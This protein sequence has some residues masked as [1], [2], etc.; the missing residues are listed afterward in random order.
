MFRTWTL[1]LSRARA[2]LRD[3]DN[4]LLL[5]FTS[6]KKLAKQLEAQYGRVRAGSSNLGDPSRVYVR[7]AQYG[8]R[9]VLS[10]YSYLPATCKNIARSDAASGCGMFGHLP[11]RV[12][13]GAQIW[14]IY[15]PPGEGSEWILDICGNTK[16]TSTI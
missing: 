1:S 13:V 5:H 2:D 15:W 10:S 14:G 4:L 3:Q 7:K 11:E 6:A 12:A 9:W 16:H 8:W